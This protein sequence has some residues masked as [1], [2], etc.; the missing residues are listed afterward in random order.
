M[1]NCRVII[2][3]SGPAGFTSAIYLA[4]AGISPKLIHGPLPGGQLTTTTEVENFPGFPDGILGPEL[5]SRMEAQAKRFGTEIIK[6]QVVGVDLLP[7]EK[8]IDAESQRFQCDAVIIATGAS[9]KLIGLAEERELLGYGVSTCATCDGAFFKNKTI[10]VV[11]GGDSACEEALFLTR[12]VSRVYLI[13]RRDELRASKIMQKRV[14]DNQSIVP[15]WSRTIEK[16]EGS[17]KE[18]V[19]SLVLKNIKT[20]SV[21]ILPVE[22]LFVAIGHTPN[23]S[24]FREQVELDEKG[25]VITKPNSTKTNIEGVYA[26]GDVQDHYF[27]QAITAAGS[28]CMA[29]IEL[30]R[31]LETEK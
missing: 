24:I 2:I 29:A 28:G 7:K 14:L 20:S 8:T 17:R 27:R 4:R 18:G 3:G 23:T 26:C 31:W 21:E 12:F 22:G 25:Y 19:T 9:A 6:S 13:H 10:A 5:M 11:G 15:L 30:E 16:I 1:N